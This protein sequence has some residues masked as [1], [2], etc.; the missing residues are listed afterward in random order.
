MDNVVLHTLGDGYWSNAERAVRITKLV[1]PCVS[2]DDLYGELRVYFDTTSWDVEQLGLIYTDTL[3]EFE[4]R[5]WLKTLGY[6]PA[7][8]SYSEQGM[9]EVDYVSFDAGSE[10]ISSWIKQNEVE[11]V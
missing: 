11:Y 1:V 8:V 2:E 4:L 10:F 9:Q 6:N 7:D 5:E 3:F